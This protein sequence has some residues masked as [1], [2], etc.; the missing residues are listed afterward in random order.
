MM[1]I[2]KE[3]YG[4]GGFLFDFI[5]SLFITLLISLT[6]YFSIDNLLIFNLEENSIDIYSSLITVFGTLVGFIITSFSLLFTFNPDSDNSKKL[7]KHPEF[8][9]I[10]RT[11][12]KTALMILF[13]T[14][15]LV[16][17]NSFNFE[18]IFVNLIFL[19]VIVLVF[20]NIMRCIY[21]LHFIIDF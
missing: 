4:N 20:L 9:R 7:K 1:Y 2:I 13:L 12:I 19:E 16:F 3:K 15:L 11:F 14:F 10:L 18:N 8:K 5:L 6:L 21:F 17:I